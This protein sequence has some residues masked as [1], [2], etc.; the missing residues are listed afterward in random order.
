M[1]GCK[2]RGDAHDSCTSWF[3]MAA[4]E[5]S[6]EGGTYRVKIYLGWQDSE[7]MDMCMRSA[8]KLCCAGSHHIRII[9]ICVY[10]G[11]C[12]AS[13]MYVWI[14][15]F[16]FQLVQSHSHSPLCGLLLLPFVFDPLNVVAEQ[17][18]GD[19]IAAVAARIGYAVGVLYIRAWERGSVCV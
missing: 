12:V 1:G 19:D 13:H 16:A 10:I 5:A 6:E 3:G 15:G 4:C 9:C 7:S 17:V 14:C 11:V 8:E 18:V 2:A